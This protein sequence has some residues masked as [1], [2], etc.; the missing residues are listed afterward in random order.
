M[1]EFYLPLCLTSHSSCYTIS[2]DFVLFFIYVVEI[3][4]DYPGELS[5]GRRF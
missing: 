2:Y 1:L 4:K 5:H 3:K